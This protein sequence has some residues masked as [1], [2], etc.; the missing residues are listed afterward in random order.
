[1]N[2]RDVTVVCYHFYTFATLATRIRTA[3]AVSTAK[4]D[5]D[6]TV[7]NNHLET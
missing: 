4:M 5:A 1:M 2:Y 3:V 7:F 6:V